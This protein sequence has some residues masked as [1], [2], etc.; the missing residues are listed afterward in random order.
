MSTNYE[1]RYATNPEDFKTYDTE[2]IRKDFLIKGLFQED[3]VQLVYTHFDRY[4]AGGAVPANKDL[5]LETIDPLKADYFLERR[6]LGIINIGGAGSVSV[7]GKAMKVGFKEALYV[8]RGTKE[9]IFSSDHQDQPAM[10]YLN[11]APAHHS[12]PTQLISREDAEIVE[13][14]ALETSNAR[15]IRKLIV[16]SIV[17]TCQLQMGM[18]E[19]KTGSVWNTM[20]AH[21]HDRRMEVYLYFELPEDQAV[22]HFMGQPQ[23]SKPVWLHN[24]DAVISPPWSM[25][26]GSGTSNYTFI[27]GMAGENLDYGD[28]DGFAPTEMQ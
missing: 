19:L 7:D 15:T 26:C 28:M 4:I 27:W 2:R 1:V 21:V 14:G 5:K 16:N 13:L 9:V 10:F 20:P 23:A 24:Q 6:E 3:Q 8:G 25:H 12:Y 11:S 18:T 17:K 22:C